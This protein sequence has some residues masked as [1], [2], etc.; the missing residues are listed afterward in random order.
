MGYTHCT[1]PD[2]TIR[3]YRDYKVT[4]NPVTKLDNYSI[5]NPEGLYTTLGGVESYKN[6]DLNQAY[7]Q[8]LLDA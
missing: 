3:I 8:L 5:P 4:L 2:K 6:L 7:Q 1:H